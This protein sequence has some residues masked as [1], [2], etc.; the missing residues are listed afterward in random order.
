MLTCCGLIRYSWYSAFVKSVL[1]L[2]TVLTCLLLTSEFYTKFRFTSIPTLYQ[3]KRSSTCWSWLMFGKKNVVPRLP[4]Y[5]GPTFN[6][7]RL[8]KVF[9]YS[10]S[11]LC[12]PINDSAACCCGLNL[13]LTRMCI[14]WSRVHASREIWA[15]SNEAWNGQNVDNSSY[16]DL[17]M[18]FLHNILPDQSICVYN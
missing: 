10:C 7:R 11:V 18:M 15:R 1:I 8:L 14:I 16:R 6:R 3:Q 17:I 2:Q 13:S 12:A 5:V 9:T 4:A